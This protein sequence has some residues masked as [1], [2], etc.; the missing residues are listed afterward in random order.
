MKSTL[1]GKIYTGYTEHCCI[2]RYA[3]SCDYGKRE[4]HVPTVPG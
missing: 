4:S 3:I 2:K 1:Y